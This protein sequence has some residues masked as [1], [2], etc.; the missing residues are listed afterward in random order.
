MRRKN[1]DEGT[2][3]NRDQPGRKTQQPAGCSY[4]LCSGSI[5][6]ER[7][8]ADSGEKTSAGIWRGPVRLFA[9][10]FDSTRGPAAA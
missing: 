10:A 6:A 7:E 8:G 3:G 2:S 9:V 1:C 5:P 4:A